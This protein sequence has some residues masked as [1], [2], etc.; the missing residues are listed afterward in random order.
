MILA[1]RS[2]ANHTRQRK[3]HVEGG[4]NCV[5]SIHNDDT[6]QLSIAKI[7]VFES[8]WLQ[9]SGLGLWLF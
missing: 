9:V 2:E 5:D 3:K 6:E 7:L 8:S 4:E 1:S